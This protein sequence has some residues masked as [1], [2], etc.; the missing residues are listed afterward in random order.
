MD[1]EGRGCNIQKLGEWE[2]RDE[3]EEPD[4]GHALHQAQ[5]NPDS[6]ASNEQQVQAKIPKHYVA[7]V[8]IGELP[9]HLSHSIS[10]PAC[11]L[12]KRCP[13]AVAS[14]PGFLPV[15]GK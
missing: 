10:F 15:F 3:Y 13:G 7:Q 12:Q 5:G 14:A 4:K 11:Q 9:W 6:G 1:Q 8:S 2:E